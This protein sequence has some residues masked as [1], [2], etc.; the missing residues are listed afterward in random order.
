[1]NLINFL[2]KP[3]TQNEM[4]EPIVSESLFADKEKPS[5]FDASD[6]PE[7]PTL[8]KFLHANYKSKGINDGF[9][10]HST[11]ILE[12]AKLEIKTEF[13][14]LVDK[15]IENLNLFLSEKRIAYAGIKDLSPELTNKLEISIE[16]D[17]KKIDDL[18][19]QKELSAMDEGWV[20]KSVRSYE[21][22]FMEGAKTFIEGETFLKSIKL[23]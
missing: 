13:R 18:K 2:K 12:L 8:L 4:A 11:E 21:I 22:G 7:E 17:E 20:M 5:S 6:R 23:I 10:H 15:T 3:K 14:F 16:A 19:Y 9:E 1:M